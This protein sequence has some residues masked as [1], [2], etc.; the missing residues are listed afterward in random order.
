MAEP[1]LAIF[2]RYPSPGKVKTR[3]I[4][5]LG[6][7]AASLVYRKLVDRTLDAARASGLAFELRVTGAE[8]ADFRRWLG[9]GL[10]LV[11]Q[12]EGDLGA[13]MARVAAPAILIGSDAPGLTGAHI[14]EA[15]SRLA[16]AEV[17]IGPASD[18][19]YYLIGFNAPVPFLFS[20]MAWSTEEVFRETMRRLAERGM[21]P[22]LLPELADVDEADD[23]AGWPE[24]AP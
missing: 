23:L 4:P 19:G 9:N 13:R 12:G 6:P 5:A 22:A 7:E 11:D 21:A 24:L 15:A 3:L 17:V 18:G 8:P 16:A 14:A 2:L 1:R 20:D 10:A